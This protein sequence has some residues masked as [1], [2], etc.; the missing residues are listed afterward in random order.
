LCNPRTGSLTQRAIPARLWERDIWE[1]DIG[2]W[3]IEERDFGERDI[4]E[5]DILEG[6]IRETDIGETVTT[7]LFAEELLLH[8]DIRHVSGFLSI[9][10]SWRCW[11]RFLRHHKPQNL[12][13]KEDMSLR[14]SW[15][16]ARLKG[17]WA[18][19]RHRRLLVWGM[20]ANLLVLLR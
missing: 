19:G 17:L 3:D 18:W 10:Q 14:M 13:P 20:L 5:R 12:R 1:R 2:E 6:N 16:R 11:A 8:I 15:L 7:C 4:G 9:S